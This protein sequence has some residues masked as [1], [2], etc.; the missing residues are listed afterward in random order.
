MLLSTTFYWYRKSQTQVTSK[1]ASKDHVEVISFM[2]DETD[3]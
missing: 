3:R 2:I 1:L